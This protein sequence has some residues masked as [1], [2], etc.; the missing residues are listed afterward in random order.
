L[1]RSDNSN[2]ETD[3]RAVTALVVAKR[4]SRVAVGRPLCLAVPLA[5]TAITQ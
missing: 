2:D 3:E 5:F 4:S 1:L